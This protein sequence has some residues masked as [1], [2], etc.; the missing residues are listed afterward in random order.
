M[1]YNSS[2][3]VYTFKGHL[4][5]HRS[6]SL[7]G[8]P[9][10]VPCDREPKLIERLADVDMYSQNINYVYKVPILTLVRNS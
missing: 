1:E 5:G 9:G 3:L 4:E 8:R 6:L 7:T 10:V 2:N